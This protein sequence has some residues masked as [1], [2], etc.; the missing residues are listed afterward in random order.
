MLEIQNTVDTAALIILGFHCKTPQQAFRRG[1][2]GKETLLLFPITAKQSIPVVAAQLE[3][4]LA[5]KLMKTN[6]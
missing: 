2:L 4:R 5:T 6:P 1:V 3:E